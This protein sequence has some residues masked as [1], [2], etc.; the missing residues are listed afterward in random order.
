MKRFLRKLFPII[1]A[2]AILL[3]I[4][5]YFL[6]FDPGFT[7]D[8]LL[9]QARRL[10]DN[11]NHSVAVWLY[12]LAYEQ[13]DGS[14]EVAIEL[15][16]QFKD[17]GNYSKAEYT[18]RKALE[19]NPV[20]E[21]YIA[22][23][24]TY[25]E[26]GK[27]RDAVLML[28]NTDRA[29]QAQLSA[30]RPSAP[31]A[32]D[33]SGSYHSYLSV[34]I[35][36]DQGTLY[37]STDS[38]YPS[39]ET[40]AYTG[41]IVLPYGET[42]IFAIS[43][44]DNGLVSP[45]SVFHYQVSDVVEVVTFTDAAF[46]AAV[47]EALDYDADHAI[48]SNVLWDVTELTLPAD[49]ASC[50]DLK[51]LPN[52]ETLVIDHATFDNLDAICDLDQLQSLSITGSILTTDML[53]CIAT[54]TKLQAL[55]LSDCS[56][57][58]VAALTTLTQL[59]KLDLSENAIRDVSGLTTMTKLT[60]LD[61]RS[62]AL[63][64]LSGLETLTAVEYLD[65]SYNSLVS[66]KSIENLTE[67]TYLNLSSNALRSLDGVENLTKL[68]RF[69]AQYN[70]L[71]DVEVLAACQMLEYLDVSHNTLLNIHVAAELTSLQEL[72]FGYNDVSQLPK[73]KT[74]CALRIINGE[75]NLLSSLN[76]LAGLENLELVYM[77]YN[78]EISNINNL[79]K[80]PELDEVYVYGTNVRSVSKLTEA[81]IYVVYSP[82]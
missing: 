20:P 41:P 34:E 63:I 28:E 5:W 1:I 4:G 45:L 22:L 16:Q 59:K 32:S 62:N 23:S 8:L 75:Y 73:F 37:I 66:T 56:I 55:T 53:S 57:S 29:M 52:L 33:P 70:E 9:R 25:V 72:Y 44:G 48:Y 30:L 46:E 80:C 42:T 7:R 38:D 10:E 12:N 3:S 68:T 54:R 77:D 60:Y 51:W 24:K 49:V 47:R 71:L 27:L 40:D 19:E 26:Q 76:N 69:I 43:V 13:F 2:A 18:L 65:V 17:I 11:G 50:D 79:I 6:E 82:K 31:V 74:D 15:A 58:S 78:T 21:L 14:A 64:Q 67:L 39:T 35:F 61:L 36:C 81:G